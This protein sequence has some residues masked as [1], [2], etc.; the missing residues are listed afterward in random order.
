M[1]ILLTG[2]TG[3]VGSYLAPV[4]AQKTEVFCLVRNGKSRVNN[5]ELGGIPENQI[6]D[7]DITENGCGLNEND[8]LAL[9]KKGINQIIHSAALLKFDNKLTEK[10]W[11][12]NYQGTQ[13]V[14]ELAHILNVKAFHYISTAYASTQRNPYEASKAKAEKLVKASNIPHS[15][16]RLGI[17]VGHSETGYIKSFDGIYGY[18]AGLYRMALKERGHFITENQIAQNDASRFMLQVQYK[19]GYPLMSH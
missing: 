12:T 13:R 16:Y 6:L 1:S 2:L 8:L 9:Q 19:F 11:Q 10:V 14:L 4:L 7:G 17:V 15:I 18:L 3:A 5:G